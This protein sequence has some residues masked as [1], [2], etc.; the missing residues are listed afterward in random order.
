[1]DPLYTY[2]YTPFPKVSCVPYKEE[3]A[4][5]ACGLKG[6]GCNYSIDVVECSEEWNYYIGAMTLIAW[7]A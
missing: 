3:E 5:S 4:E 1:M 2:P 7:Y 6:K